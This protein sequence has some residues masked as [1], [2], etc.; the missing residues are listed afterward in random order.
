MISTALTHEGEKFFSVHAMTKMSIC[1]AF[2]CVTAY[3]SFPLPFTPGMVTALTVALGVTAFV[4]TPLQTFLVLLVYVFL[5]C[6]GLPV[7]AGGTSGISK[8]VGPVGG[9]II[10]WVL[11][12]PMVSALKGKSISFRRYALV[13]I[14]LGMPVTYLGGMISLM[15]FMDLTL[16]EAFAIGVLVYIPADLMKCLLAAFLGVRINKALEQL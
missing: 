1:V 16:E 7:F 8:I 9:F 4:L 13:D 15:F 2:C 11:V 3:L 14:L 5:G 6:A 12:Y 10:A